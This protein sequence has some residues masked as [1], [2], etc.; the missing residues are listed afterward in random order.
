M[1]KQIT[2]PVD[3]RTYNVILASDVIEFEVDYAK[4]IFDGTCFPGKTIYLDTGDDFYNNRNTYLLRPHPTITNFKKPIAKNIIGKNDL[5]NYFYNIFIPFTNFRRVLWSCINR[6]DGSMG[7]Q[8]E[9]YGYFNDINILGE[10]NNHVLNNKNENSK[11]VIKTK[12]EYLEKV[13]SAQ[14]TALQNAI[15]AIA[16]GNP[17]KPIKQQDV[18]N[19]LN[20]FVNANAAIATTYYVLLTE[21]DV[22][23]NLTVSY[24]LTKQR[25]SEIR[26][27]DPQGDAKIHPGDSYTLQSKSIL[28]FTNSG[29]SNLDYERMMSFPNCF[30]GWSMSP[31]Q[32]NAGTY[33]NGYKTYTLNE[34]QR[35][36]LYH[37]LELWPAYIPPWKVIYNITDAQA[38]SNFTS[39][40]SVRR[41]EDRLQNID[42]SIGIKGI[43]IFGTVRPPYRQGNSTITVSFAYWVDSAG[44][45]YTKNQTVTLTGDLSLTAVFNTD[46]IATDLS[47]YELMFRTI[48]HFEPDKEAYYQG[49]YDNANVGV[50]SPNGGEFSITIPEIVGAKRIEAEFSG[51]LNEQ[52]HSHQPE[53]VGWPGFSRV[54]LYKDGYNAAYGNTHPVSWGGGRSAIGPGAGAY[55][56]ENSTIKN[57]SPPENHYPGNLFLF[58]YHWWRDNAD[59]ATQYYRRFSGYITELLNVQDVPKI[60]VTLTPPDN[61]QTI[62]TNKLK[63]KVYEYDPDKTIGSNSGTFGKVYITRLNIFY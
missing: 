48:R 36:N 63:F 6:S 41:I 34:G 5:I 13:P 1:S 62:A 9:G 2:D 56:Q 37:D 19:L 20:A 32:V 16:V 8:Y 44:R 35:L 11:F 50:I 31:D 53:Y 58:Q 23:R 27:V 43:D 21:Q 15:N 45:T 38:A 18:T 30:R 12:E 24:H 29:E 33:N 51:W 28:Q 40:P 39:V 54:F 55:N 61:R 26:R 25:N 60:A 59:R 7:S 22:S 49:Q 57:S 4:K 46:I 3:N 17:S 47:K 42:F 14:K 10:H 52:H